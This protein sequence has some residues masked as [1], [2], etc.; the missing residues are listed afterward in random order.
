MASELEFV[1][2]KKFVD[3][4]SET[5]NPKSADKGIICN[6]TDGPRAVPSSES[7]L[8]NSATVDDVA[9]G[10]QFKVKTSTGWK[11]LDAAT[12]KQACSQ[13]ALAENV[14][15]A[16]DA[17]KP[18][19]AGGYAYYKD[20]IVAC[21]GVTYRFKVNHSSGAWNSAE[22]T[23]YNSGDFLKLLI[24]LE[25]PEYMYAVEDENRLFL[26][27]LKIDGSVEWAKGV[28]LPVKKFVEDNVEIINQAITAL[29]ESVSSIS[30]TLL[31]KVDKV[32]GRSL[33]DSDVAEH[34][35]SRENIEYQYALVDS[36][37]RIIFSVA[38][39]G[40]IEFP[41]VREQ[42]RSYI[43]G[44]GGLATV[45]YV[46]G[47]VAEEEERALAAERIL[48]DAIDN[49]NPTQVIGGENNPDEEFLTSINDK[50][51]LKDKL[52]GIGSFGRKIFRQS[53][54]FDLDDGDTI[55]EIR[56]AFNLGGASIEVPSNCIL[57]FNGGQLY[58]GAL[59]GDDTRII[60]VNDFIFGSDISFS[61][62]WLVDKISSRMIEGATNA[63]VLK[64]L[65][66]LL[67]DDYFNEFYITKESN[68]YVFT[69]VQNE[70][71][72]I[73]LKSN[74]KLIVDGTLQITPNG[75]THY[76]LVNSVAGKK[77]IEMCGS[78]TISGDADDHDYVTTQSS[79][80]W[81]HC[82]HAGGS[83]ILIHGLTL[84]NATGDGIDTIADDIHIHDVV[85]SHCGRQGISVSEGH[86]IV[87]E[88]VDISDIYRTSPRGAIDVEG[89]R[90]V[91]IKN[92]KISNVVMSSSY[93]LYFL[94]C[95]GVD[96]HNIVSSACQQLLFG[97]NCKNVSIR[98][99]K[100][101]GT[102]AGAVQKWI[103]FENTCERV[104]LDDSEIISE[105]A[106]NADIS[107]VRVG[108][109]LEFLD[110]VIVTGSPVAGSVKYGSGKYVQF[111]GTSW[112]NFDGSQAN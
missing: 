61:G 49:I 17:T 27:G 84:Q 100:N 97:R 103:N 96:V 2:F 83:N 77:N 68:S 106:V 87:I 93:G 5:E 75:Y 20:E 99:L 26:F 16:F 105:S 110:A 38:E 80:E 94:N 40:T 67:N 104:G 37:E 98:K 44:V 22:V 64:K 76:R 82:I 89:E 24:T 8:T 48:Q 18:N 90:G 28:P 23:R 58:N 56:Y 1:T 14:A 41:Y 60:R 70:D 32:Q 81:G 52:A 102:V 101:F 79:H 59:V 69:P 91:T 74:T 4:L 53:D 36:H 85:I 88:N 66:S 9:S 72:F 71:V 6:E 63:N 42:I 107:N 73:S 30:D 21:Q 15:Q 25:N 31:L 46:D 45:D 3:N 51:T 33:I 57:F 92:V 19:D 50:I 12:L 34:N 35:L 47:K 112:V 7:A 108:P 78:G 65:C 39:N 55:Y 95:D 109:T 54:S 43:E 86:N 10:T 13:N 29:Q 11:K 62:S 111:N